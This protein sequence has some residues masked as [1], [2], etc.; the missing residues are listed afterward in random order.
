LI[1]I[2]QDEKI[3]VHKVIDVLEDQLVVEQEVKLKALV[4]EKAKRNVYQQIL[5]PNYSCLL[6]TLTI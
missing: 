2:L 3:L 6:M 1:K 4:K 5:Q